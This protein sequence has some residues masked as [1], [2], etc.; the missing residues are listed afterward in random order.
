MANRIAL[1]RIFIEGTFDWIVKGEYLQVYQE[2]RF[3][4]FNEA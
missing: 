3:H 2:I 1:H 4:Y